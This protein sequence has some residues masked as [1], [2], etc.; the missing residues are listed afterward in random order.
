MSFDLILPFL[1]PIADLI[2]DP[3]VSEIMVNGSHRVF[4]ER[5]GVVSP[6]DGVTIEERSLRVAVKNI[7]RLLGDDVSEESPILDARLPDGSRVAAVFPPCSLGGTTLTIRKFHTRFWTCDEL[8]RVGM[9]TDDLVDLVRHALSSRDNILISGGTGTGKTTL[10]NALA[11]L[12]PESD[13]IVVIEETAELQ[14]THSNL[15]RFEARRSQPDVSAVTIR[16]LLRATLRH[17][18]DRIIVGEVRGGEAFDLL[19]TLNTGH[20]G[21]L[22]TIH[23]NSA[24]LALARFASCVLQSGIDLPY[25]AIRRLI[26]ESIDLVIHLERRRGVRSVSQLIAVMGYQSESDVYEVHAPWRSSDASVASS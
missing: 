2:Q 21:S 4:V 12:L 25:P 14:F 19:Q 10:L 7:A 8:V 11:T 9:I 23:A 18:P 5:D 24:E 22:S 26:S 3:T 1:R 15:V 16:D 13:R 17:R 6:V 20:S